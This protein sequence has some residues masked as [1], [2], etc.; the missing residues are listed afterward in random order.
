MAS[1]S[2]KERQN[3][4]VWYIVYAIIDDKGKRKQM[5]LR[6]ESED[7]AKELL[8]KVEEYERL[9]LVYPVPIEN[10]RYRIGLVAGQS[11]EVH[12]AAMTVR[13]MIAEYFEQHCRDGYWEASTHQSAKAISEHYIFPFIGDILISKITPRDLQRYYL[14]LPTYPTVRPRK[15]T[16]GTISKRTIRE[17]HKILRP[18][19]AY[20]VTLGYIDRNPATELRLP[21]VK[22]KKRERWSDSE[23]IQA[24]SLCEDKD[25]KL[26]MEVIYCLTARTGE[27]LAIQW[28]NVHIFNEDAA[29]PYIYIDKELARLNKADIEATDTTVYLTFP[30]LSPH[31][32]TRLVLKNPK[33]EKSV[34]RVYIPMT[35]A[36]ELRAYKAAQDEMLADTGLPNYGLVFCHDNGRPFSGDT[37]RKRFLKFVKKHNLRPV[38]PY[39]LR[40]SGATSKLALSHDIK[41][42]QGD[43][44]HSSSKLL[45]DTYADAV[46]TNRQKLAVGMESQLYAS[47]ESKKP[48]KKK[49][50]RKQET[51]RPRTDESA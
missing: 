1:I 25:L 31:Q 29:E 48:K 41:A 7:D 51:N 8:S 5:W 28:E 42:V 35:L 19:F 43:M 14:K 47:E 2:S 36:E 33:T 38:D 23:V 21:R 20:A 46:D 11:D 6:C 37:L 45:L 24:I 16:P 18:A 15:N 12:A 13:G 30:P 39:S 27:A 40:H 49:R 32:S 9:N 22:T 34:R 44:G 10:R 4:P 26:L 3:G 50:G 17:I